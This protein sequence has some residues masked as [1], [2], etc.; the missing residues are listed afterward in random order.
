MFGIGWLTLVEL[1]CHA[2]GF[3]V[4]DVIVVLSM[5][6]VHFKVHSAHCAVAISCHAQMRWCN[7]FHQS[8]HCKTKTKMSV[9][10]WWTDVTERRVCNAFSRGDRPQKAATTLFPAKEKATKPRESDCSR[11]RW[12]SKTI[13]KCGRPK[14]AKR[15]PQSTSVR[16][17]DSVIQVAQVSQNRNLFAPSFLRRTFA[18]LAAA[19]N[20]LLPSM[21]LPFVADCVADS[22]S[23]KQLEDQCLTSDRILSTVNAISTRHSHCPIVIQLPNKDYHDCLALPTSVTG[24][25]PT[26]TTLFLSSSAH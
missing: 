26:H 9:I 8:E 12:S 20:T 18:Q 3:F 15:A 1:E 2:K 11:R 21:A 19:R 24:T 17:T 5:Q 6:S 16:Q 14:R 25:A 13:E 7:S 10:R 23:R 22:T 4:G